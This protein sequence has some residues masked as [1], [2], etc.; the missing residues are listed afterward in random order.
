MVF[1]CLSQ[2]A[3]AVEH[4]F[5]CSFAMCIPSSGFPAGSVG[6]ESAHNAGARGSIPGLGRSCGEA[7]CKPLHYARLENPMVDR[8]AWRARVHGVARS[9]TRLSD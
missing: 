8:G 7:N 9:Q 2:L 1:I 5:M 4:L 6:K 3:G